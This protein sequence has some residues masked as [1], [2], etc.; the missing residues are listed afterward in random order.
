MKGYKRFDQSKVTESMK[1]LLRECASSDPRV[2]EAAR[3]RFASE[4]VTPALRSG[5]MSGDIITDIFDATSFDPATPTMY[6]LDFLVP[7][8]ERDFTAYTVP[9]Q[10]RIP[11][12][13][14]E[15]D[16]VMIPTFQSAN[17]IDVNRRYLQF[18]R[19]DVLSRM[20]EVLE[21]GMIKKRNDDGWHLL[22]TGGLD[23]NIVVFDSEAS[24]G[25]FTKRLVSL[26]KLIMRRNGGGNSTSVDRF[27]LSDLYISPENQEDI[28]NWGLDQID[29]V[30][31]REIYLAPDNS[32]N[33]VFNVNLHA[34]DELGEDQ[35]YQLFFLNDLGGALQASDVELVVGLDLHTSPVFKM[36]V[37]Q[38]IES[39]PDDSFRRSRQVSWISEM[40][41][42]FGLLDNRPV[43]LGCC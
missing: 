24:Q 26:M 37:V 28:R 15:G 22:L 25:Q 40:E 27:L 32:I 31:R 36:P 21:A 43:L 9:N 20:L 1:V 7:G 6:P 12:K 13:F 5:I 30:T 10:G 29:E 3:Y 17:G 11:N 39:Y 2:A 14:V 41:T 23:R 4:I 34:I 16:Y 33:R 35:E 19:W 42:G 38:D 8:T 18:A